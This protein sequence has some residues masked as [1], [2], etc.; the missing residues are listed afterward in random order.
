M[1]FLPRFR[2]GTR[3]VTAFLIAMAIA[4][5]STANS[6]AAELDVTTLEAAEKRWAQA[7]LQN[8]EFTFKYGEFINACSSSTYHVRVSHGVS[9]RWNGCRKYW[10]EFSS[11]PLLFKF[12]RRA[13]TGE[14]QSI[15]AEFD[16]TTGH[17]V[18]VYIDYGLTD[19]FFEFEVIDFR[20]DK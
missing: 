2:R 5:S 14:H 6:Q 8:Y 13:L 20:V 19:N 10:A 12:L 11:V 15:E 9:T 4:A 18:S 7:S 1:L 17:P 3:L 16:S